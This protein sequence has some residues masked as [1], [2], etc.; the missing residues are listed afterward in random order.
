S[1]C[2]ELLHSNTIAPNTF[3][4]SKILRMIAKAQETI[5]SVDD[6]VA[7]LKRAVDELAVKRQELQDFVEDHRKVM[8]PIRILPVDIL[9]AIFMQCVGRD[10][11]SRWSPPT[12]PE[13]LLSKVCWDW[14][15]VALSIPQ[16]W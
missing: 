13:R 6:K 2:P 4:I 15:A 5:S 1:P 12:D 11:S 3:T 10:S 16:L 9:Y 8:A 14:R 7:E